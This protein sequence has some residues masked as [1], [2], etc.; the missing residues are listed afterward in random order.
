MSA[1]LFAIFIFAGLSSPIIHSSFLTIAKGKGVGYRWVFPF[2]ASSVAY[3]VFILLFIAAMIAFTP[4]Y[5]HALNV[6]PSYHETGQVIP[7]WVY[8]I[9]WVVKYYVILIATLLTLISGVVMKYM[10]PWWQSRFTINA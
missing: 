2:A 10:W 9:E 6:I 7:F 5:S 1:L 3:I 4:L 8:I